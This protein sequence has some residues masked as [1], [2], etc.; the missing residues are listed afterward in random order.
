MFLLGVSAFGDSSGACLLADGVP[1]AAAMEERFTRIKGDAGL[2]LRAVRACLRQASI[3]PQQLEHA[4]FYEKPLRRFERTFITQLANFPRSSGPFAEH[5]FHW[6][7]ERLWLKGQLSTELGVALDKILFTEHQVAHASSA[8]FASG[9]DEAAVLCV[10]GAGE[11]DS[12]ALFHGRGLQLDAVGGVRFPHSLGWLVSSVAQFLGFIPGT[13]DHKLGELARH[14]TPKFQSQFEQLLIIHADGS[15]SIDQNAFRFAF[16]VQRT[17]TPA[18]EAALG[19][20]RVP[21]ASL[22]ASGADTRDADIAA[23]LFQRL[24]QALDGLLETLRRKVPSRNL[25]LAGSLASD[26]WLNAHIAN[27]GAFERV[28]VAPASRD[29]GAAL[30]AALYAWHTGLGKPRGWCQRH[31]FFG[32][33]IRPQ[34][35]E[36]GSGADQRS[37]QIPSDASAWG[38][39]VADRLARGQLV[40]IARGAA[41]FSSRSLGHRSV[42]ASAADQG[43][44][45]KLNESLKRRE[46][47]RPMAIAVTEDAAQRLFEIPAAGRALTRY[48]LLAVRPLPALLKRAPHL[49]NIDGTCVIQCVDSEH[50]THLDCCLRELEARTGLPLA[51]CVSLNARGDTTVRTLD[52]ALR[53][54]DRCKLDALIIEDRVYER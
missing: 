12:T 5:L 22:R 8:F 3:E 26:P 40:G 30:G 10:D 2:P 33:S 37:K 36:S 53:L 41:E 9:F 20:R 54:F 4:I 50:D 42:L 45:R 35:G 17:F 25:C 38:M 14:G 7:G 34:E 13:D 49:S 27:H 15:Y 16:D 32:E 28:F 52:D 21:G 18:L 23:S 19:P 44:K 1:V 48:K 11:W 46:D 51:Y 47:F 24:G 29:A 6:L 43:A 39:H 31:A